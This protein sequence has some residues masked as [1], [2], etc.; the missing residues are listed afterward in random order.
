MDDEHWL[1]VR[2]LQLVQKPSPNQWEK[3]RLISSSNKQYEWDIRSDCAYYASLRAFPFIFRDSVEKY[4]SVVQDRAFSPYLTIEF[5]KS[6]EPVTT[7]RNQV[8][9]ASAIALYNRW[10][11]KRAALQIMDED[12]WSEEQKLQLRHYGITFIGSK[13]ELWF[14]S[15][16][17][18]DDWTGCTMSS[19]HRGD[20]LKLASVGLLLSSINDIHYWGITVHA[21]L[22]KADVDTIADGKTQDRS[23]LLEKDEQASRSTD[24]GDEAK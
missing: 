14:S 17:T 16:K 9:V 13:W 21:R 7:A 11:L 12:N 24:K 19:M 20:C 22:C 10:R 5:K 6:D 8:A 18:Y 2:M 3:P 15:P 23:W 4:V 1:P